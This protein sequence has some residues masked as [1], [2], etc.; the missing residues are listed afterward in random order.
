MTT[1]TSERKFWVKIGTPGRNR[2][3]IVTA[4]SESDAVQRVVALLL[5]DEEP[6]EWID[7]HLSDKNVYVEERQ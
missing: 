3:R 5:A 4:T 2:S 1:T 6:Q 7:K